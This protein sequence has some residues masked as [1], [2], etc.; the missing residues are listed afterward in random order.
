MKIFFNEIQNIP[1]LNNVYSC[2]SFKINE[3]TYLAIAIVGGVDSVIYKWNGTNFEEFQFISIKE[4]YDWESFQIDGETYIVGAENG[5]D[6]NV[7][8]YSKIFSCCKFSL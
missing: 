1:Y 5:S 3:E 7:L 8:Y 6:V 4:V 2:E